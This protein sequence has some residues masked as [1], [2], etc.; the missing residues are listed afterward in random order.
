MIQKNGLDTHPDCDMILKILYAGED[1]NMDIAANGDLVIKAGGEEVVH[2]VKKDDIVT[3][4]TT[5]INPIFA[6]T[7]AIADTP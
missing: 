7:N 4:A 5:D 3:P 2:K 6:D 1:E